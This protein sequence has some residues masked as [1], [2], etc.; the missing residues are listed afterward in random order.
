MDLGFYEGTSEALFLKALN[1]IQ[2][3]HRAN[4]QHPGYKEQYSFSSGL[5]G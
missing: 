5:H 1:L 4:E 2:L 3:I